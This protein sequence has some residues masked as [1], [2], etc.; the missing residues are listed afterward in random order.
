MPVIDYLF[1]CLIFD[2]VFSLL[3]CKTNKR[4]TGSDEPALQFGGAEPQKI[5]G[6]KLEHD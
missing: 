4:L 6:L 1:F 2:I 3:E 5:V